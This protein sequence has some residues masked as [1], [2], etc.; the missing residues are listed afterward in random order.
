MDS[1]SL[2]AL[3]SAVVTA[4]RGVAAD[5][6]LA[7]LATLPDEII[8]GILKFLDVPELYA[9]TKVSWGFSFFF[10]LPFLEGLFID[11]FSAFFQPFS[12]FFRG[13]PVFLLLPGRVPGRLR[14]RFV[15]GF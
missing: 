9:L 4:F 14:G 13:F 2:S 10:S 3:P 7:S 11:F 5:A 12:A 8:L 15:G 6:G 1:A